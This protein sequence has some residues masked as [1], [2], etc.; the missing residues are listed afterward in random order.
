M[1]III[2]QAAVCDDFAARHRIGAS[3]WRKEDGFAKS[4]LFGVLLYSWALK[5]VDGRDL[6]IV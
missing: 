5:T 3:P 4:V 2:H 1:V 6:H